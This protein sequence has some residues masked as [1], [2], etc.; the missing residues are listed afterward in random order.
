ML[1]FWVTCLKD[2]SEL[3]KGLMNVNS[4]FPAGRVFWEVQE[5][6]YSSFGLSWSSPGRGMVVQWGRHV[7]KAGSFGS[8]LALYSER[9]EGL[10]TICMCACH[11]CVCVCVCHAGYQVHEYHMRLTLPLSIISGF[12]FLNWLL[13]GF[14][15]DNLETKVLNIMYI[16]LSLLR[17]GLL[18]RSGW[19]V[20]LP[21][22]L[23]YIYFITIK[24]N[25]FKMLA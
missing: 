21:P 22:H 13:L 18:C 24:P 25:R 15:V 3:E 23:P 20:C 7:V 10:K 14:F 8:E 11:E 6:S 12:G 2:M 9:W 5:E 17:Q 19:P 1:T 16:V 4:T